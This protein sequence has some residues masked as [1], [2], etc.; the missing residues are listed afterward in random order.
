[1]SPNT[2]WDDV[3][4]ALKLIFMPW[5]WKRG[6]AVLEMEEEFKKYLGVKQ[7]VSFNSGR[8]GLLAILTA[9]GLEPGS[10]VLL[11][12]FTCN[13]AVNPILWSGLKPIYV[14]CDEN[15]FNIDIEDLKRKISPNSRVLMVQHTFGLPANMDE[16]LSLV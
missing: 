10:E 1:M 11:Q 6:K 14:D 8:T 5:L 15:N 16:I 13:A 4:L 3:W 2:E 7:A 12:A 9:L